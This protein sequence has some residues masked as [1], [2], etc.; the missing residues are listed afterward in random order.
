MP[1]GDNWTK[2]PKRIIFWKTA[3]GNTSPL[4]KLKSSSKPPGGSR[5]EARDR[6]LLFLMFRHGLRVSEACAPQLDQVDVESRVLHV[7]RP[8]KDSRP[9]TRYASRSCALS[10]H[11]LPFG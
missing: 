10:K 4:A 1:E 11:G 8:K 2:T 9:P 3:T 6:C 5:H 7:A